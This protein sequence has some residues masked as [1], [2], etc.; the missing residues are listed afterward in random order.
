MAFHETAIISSGARIDPNVAIGP[1]SVI[2]DA[3]IGKDCII[4][5][6]VVISD[7]VEIGDSVEI[8]AGAIIGREPK[9]AGATSRPI[10]FSKGISIGSG[11]S[12]G[13]HAIIYHDVEIGSRTLIGD[14]AS[15]R[16]QCRV[17]NECIIS[18]Y[19]TINYNTIVGDRVKVM[20][21]THLTGNMTIADDAFV[22]CLVATANDNR[23]RNGYGDHVTGPSIGRE[24]LVGAGATVLPGIEIGENAIVAAGS[25]V[26]RKVEAGATV[27]G[28]PASPRG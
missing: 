9:G 11:C 14:G 22:S 7:G 4:H 21:L 13:P 19:V 25:V 15:I 17:G 1:F 28:M 6:H 10:E 2:G 8:F 12:I 16:E 3:V 27:F 18:R 24:A 20:D 23:V 5:S 26:T